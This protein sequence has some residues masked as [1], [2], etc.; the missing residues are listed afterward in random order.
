MWKSVETFANISICVSNSIS[1]TIRAFQTPYGLDFIHAFR[2]FPHIES[3]HIIMIEK[4]PFKSTG[5]LSTIL[6]GEEQIKIK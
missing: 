4:S 3:I 6:T 1:I 5:M 2:I